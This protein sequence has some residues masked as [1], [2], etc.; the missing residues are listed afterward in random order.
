M[1][2]LNVYVIRIREFAKSKW[3]RGSIIPAG[4]TEENY[5]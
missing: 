2:H 5:F 3:S 1:K 4:V